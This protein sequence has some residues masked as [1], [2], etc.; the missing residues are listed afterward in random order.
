MKAI[1]NRNGLTRECSEI[2]TINV[3][4]PKKY[5]KNNCQLYTQHGKPKSQAPLTMTVTV[6]SVGNGGWLTNLVV[7][8]VRL[9][10]SV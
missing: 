6:S 8:K 5:E 10:P 9:F 2:S 1:N 7:I 4:Y 3:Y